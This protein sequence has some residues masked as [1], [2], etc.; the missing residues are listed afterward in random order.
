[1]GPFTRVEATRSK[2]TEAKRFPLSV[3]LF[4]ESAKFIGIAE[5]FLEHE[6]PL[7]QLSLSQPSTAMYQEGAVCRG[8]RE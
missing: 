7:P 4:W 3:E 2:R 1:V 5:R 8:R 6:V